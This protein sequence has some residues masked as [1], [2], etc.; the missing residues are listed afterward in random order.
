[1]FVHSSL[2]LI[3][4]SR[5]VRTLITVLALVLLSS[6]TMGCQKPAEPPPV[7]NDAQL[8]AVTEQSMQ[9]MMQEQ[10]RQPNPR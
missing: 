8:K 6:I 5:C 1:M 2:R 10:K 9:R 7:T 3:T 4:P